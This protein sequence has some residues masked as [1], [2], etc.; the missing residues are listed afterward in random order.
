LAFLSV[1]PAA[2]QQIE[3]FNS[4]AF[5]FDLLAYRKALASSDTPYT[6]SIPLVK[7]LVESLRAIRSIGIEEVWAS[8]KILARAMRA[9]LAAL[10]LRLA[11]SQPGDGMTAVSFPEE[12][13][14]RVFLERLQTRFGIKLAGGQGPW[15]GKIFRIAQMGMI[16]E[17]DIL[18][19]LAALELVLVEMQQDVKLGNGVAAA[20]Q[21][22]AEAAHKG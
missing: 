9:G 7:A 12:V 4:P 13:D 15:K 17:L 1:S 20:S 16:D 11:A 2:W 21:I 22:L 5:Y 18:S 14:G 3:S 19:T 10:G 6:P 8:N